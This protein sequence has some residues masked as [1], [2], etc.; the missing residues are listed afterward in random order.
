MVGT[1]QLIILDVTEKTNPE[2][3]STISYSYGGYTHQGWIDENHRYF[4]LGDELDELRYGNKTRIITFDLKDLKILKY[5]LFM[6]GKP[7]Q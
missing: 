1:N 3:I 5:I 6:K 7:T 2:L 4:Y